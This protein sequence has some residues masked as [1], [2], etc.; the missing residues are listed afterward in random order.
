MLADF[1]L[2]YGQNYNSCFPL[3]PVAMLTA[4]LTVSCSFIIH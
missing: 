3:F 2:T 1:F 4:M